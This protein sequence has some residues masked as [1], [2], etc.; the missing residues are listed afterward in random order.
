MKRGRRSARPAAIAEQE[1]GGRLP[2]ALVFPQKPALAYSSLGWQGVLTQVRSLATLAPE[3]V[4][5]DPDKGRLVR[6]Y[7]RRGLDAFGVLAFSL[8]YEFDYL[9]LVRILMASGIT[10][11]AAKR[12]SWPLVMAGGALAFMNPAPIAPCV[13]MFWVGEAE[14]GLLECLA[15][16]AEV[17]VRHGSRHDALERVAAMPGV[18]VPGNSPLPVRRAMYIHPRH[19]GEL[20]TPVSSCFVTSDAVFRDTLLLEVNRGCPHGCR[21]CAAGYVYRPP[22]LTSLETLQNIVRH[23]QPRKVGL[24][25]TALTD[26]PELT[27]FLAWLGDQKV[28][29]SLSSLRAEGLT[30]E[31][32]DALRGL[33]TRT[34]TLALEGP[35]RSLRD[36]MNKHVREEAFLQTVAQLSRK[37]F[38]HLK[39][40][41]LVGWPG[42]T[43]ADWEEFSLFLRD[44]NQARTGG[45]VGGKTNLKL[46]TLGLGCLVPKPW[47]PLQWAAMASEQVLKERISYVRKVAKNMSGVQVRS[48]APGLARVQG[49]LARGDQRVHELIH[50]AAGLKGRE[51]DVWA[52]A[53][54]EWPRDPNWFLDRERSREEIFPWEVINPG[55]D[56]EYLWRE[57]E[58]VG[59][60]RTSSPCP[61]E[62][63]QG[64]LQAGCLKC[65]RCGLEKWL[66]T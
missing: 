22:R 19:T 14:A 46:I 40:Y 66:Q 27:R 53:L 12:P 21:F 49:L 4:F 35:S 29:V 51:L 62:I 2:I 61:M 37:G 13:D 33:G 52:A 6:P 25:G 48:D 15:V 38:N 31:L 5:W 64:G 47:T 17:H 10:P 34:V 63:A 36:A 44:V 45:V 16:L 39:I 54:G 28:D 65:R 11:E 8:T 24:V 1:W 43:D 58:K 9:H 55:L 3:P 20:E 56:R 50:L 18:Y 23:E 32:L 57:W 60:R 59:A 26:W 30:E 41:L 42:E 7:G